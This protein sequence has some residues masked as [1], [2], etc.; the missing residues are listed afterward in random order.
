VTKT[1]A[2][3]HC[4]L[5][6]TF[7]PPELLTSTAVVAV[8]MSL[9]GHERR[10][11]SALLVGRCPLCVR[12]R[13]NWSGAGSAASGHF[14]TLPALLPRQLEMPPMSLRARRSASRILNARLTTQR[15]P[16]ISSTASAGQ[17]DNSGILADS[18]GREA[19]QRPCDRADRV[20]PQRRKSAPSGISRWRVCNHSRFDGSVRTVGASDSTARYRPQW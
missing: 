10:R 9:V 2:V 4:C 16:N 18:V 12:Q 13:Q 11:R 15:P 8:T 19:I 14:Q 20:G 3:Q 1:G 7:T 5:S 17:V 6:S